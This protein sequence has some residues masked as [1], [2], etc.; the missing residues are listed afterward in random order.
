VDIHVKHTFSEQDEKLARLKASLFKHSNAA[1]SASNVL[2]HADLGHALTLCDP[3]WR[4]LDVKKH[5]YFRQT[6]YPFVMA[7]CDACKLFCPCQLFIHET[8]LAQVWRTKEQQ[9][10]DREYATIV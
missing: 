3:H 7:N 1:S 8:V 9:R 6:D 10:R 2:D 4:K 5:G